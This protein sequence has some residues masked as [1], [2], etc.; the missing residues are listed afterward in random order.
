[1]TAYDLEQLFNSDKTVKTTA[2]FQFSTVGKHI[3][4]NICNIHFF[5]GY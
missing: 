5:Q 3:P 2:T 1:M 4:A